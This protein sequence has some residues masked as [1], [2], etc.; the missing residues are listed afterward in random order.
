MINQT[1]K[2]LIPQFTV[3]GIYKNIFSMLMLY[4]FRPFNQDTAMELLTEKM[5]FAHP[6]TWNDPFEDDSDGIIYLNR[7]ACFTENTN[8]VEKDALQNLRR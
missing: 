4:R 8:D 7:Y 5:Y 6:S 1:L 3:A 2:I